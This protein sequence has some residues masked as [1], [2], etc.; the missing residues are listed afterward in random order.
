MLGY[1]DIRPHTHGYEGKQ[2]RHKDGRREV[3]A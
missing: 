1:P 3:G 2:P